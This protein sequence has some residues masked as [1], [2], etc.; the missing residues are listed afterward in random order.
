ML[1][2]SATQQIKKE[3]DAEVTELRTQIAGRDEKIAALEKS[4]AALQARDQAR[5]AKVAAIEKLL[6]ST[7]KATA[8]PASAQAGRRRGVTTS[9]TTPRRSR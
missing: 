5:D 7:D 1:N 9:I 8:R 6:R 3:K 4:V 2:V